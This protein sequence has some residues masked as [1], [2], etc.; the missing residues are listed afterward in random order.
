MLGFR[1]S[2]KGRERALR[3][4]LADFILALS[5]FWVVGLGV[6]SDMRAHA[7]PLPAVSNLHISSDGAA[8]SLA[9]ARAAESDGVASGLAKSSLGRRLDLALLSLTFAALLA[10]NLAFWRH[11]RRAYASPRRTVWRRG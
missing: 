5:L 6:S 4:G 8:P 2:G 10:G 1:T 9:S 11:L 7:V 3:R